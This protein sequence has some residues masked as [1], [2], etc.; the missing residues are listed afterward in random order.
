[1][2]ASLGSVS[3]LTPYCYIFV[4]E[5]FAWKYASTR[6]ENTVPGKNENVILIYKHRFLPRLMKSCETIPLT[7]LIFLT[8]RNILQT[9]PGQSGRFVACWP[10]IHIASS[11]IFSVYIF[12]DCHWNLMRPRYW[13]AFFVKNLSLLFIYLFIITLLPLPLSPAHT[14]RLRAVNQVKKPVHR[15]GDL[16]RHLNKVSVITPV[17]YILNL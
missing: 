9:T 10:G 11:I 7:L 6:N 14:S 12:P 1:M 5:H 15:R 8:R 2:C 17:I 4:C 16:S 13:S 3:A